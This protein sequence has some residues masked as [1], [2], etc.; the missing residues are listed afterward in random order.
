M[1]APSNGSLTHSLYYRTVF[2]RAARAKGARGDGR[3]RG[4]KDTRRATSGLFNIPLITRGNR[5]PSASNANEPPCFVRTRL[6]RAQHCYQ[7]EGVNHLVK[8]E[9][10]AR[11]YYRRITRS[12]LKGPVELS[13]IE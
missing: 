13:D 7:T 10:L 4:D 2:I 9:A 5:L 8:C 11:A 6:P 3:H 12:G 1:S